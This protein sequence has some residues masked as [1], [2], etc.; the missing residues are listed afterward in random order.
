MS[1]SITLLFLF[2]VLG[3]KVLDD[4]ARIEE[5]W[6]CMVSYYRS[7]VDPNQDVLARLH[8]VNRL[9]GNVS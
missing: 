7:A 4:L 3:T 8:E 1:L 5:P 2:D 6:C 9:T